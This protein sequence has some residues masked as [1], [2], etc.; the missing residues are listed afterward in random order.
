LGNVLTAVTFKE[1]GACTE[2]SE[3]ED[4]RAIVSCE[5]GNKHWNRTAEKAVGETSVK[6]GR[7]TDSLLS[8]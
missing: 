7:K 6:R 2:A 1:G 3:G 4:E 8:Y 5:K